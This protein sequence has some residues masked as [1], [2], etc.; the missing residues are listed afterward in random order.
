MLKQIR[1]QIEKLTKEYN[2]A[3]KIKDWKQMADLNNQLIDLENRIRYEM[4]W[5]G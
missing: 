4:Y 3:C 5:K 2:E 1:E